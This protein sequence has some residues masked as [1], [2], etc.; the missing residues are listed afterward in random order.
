MSEYYVNEIEIDGKLVLCFSDGRIYRMPH[1]AKN[2]KKWKGRWAIPSFYTNGYLRTCI[3]GRYHQVH[4]VIAKAFLKDFSES[5]TV[6]H[7]DNDPTNNRVSNLR[8]ATQLQNNLASMRPRKNTTSKYRGVSWCNTTKRWLAV[9]KNGDR[10]FRKT[11]KCEHE[12]ARAYNKAA[13]ELGFFPE[14]LN[15]IDQ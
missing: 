14:A 4:R 2:G 5:L 9:A 15:V 12:A 1:I 6:D 10:R 8:M 11:F 7:I 13:T 3:A